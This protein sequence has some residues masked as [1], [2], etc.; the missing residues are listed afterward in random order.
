MFRDL[1]DN[2][3]G[4]IKTMNERQEFSFEDS[5]S[6]YETCYPNAKFGVSEAGNYSSIS[7]KKKQIAM[8]FTREKS[9]AKF[10]V[11]FRQ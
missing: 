8:V 2:N 7:L 5:N 11:M 6:L 3:S 10:F 4:D 1:S 9:I